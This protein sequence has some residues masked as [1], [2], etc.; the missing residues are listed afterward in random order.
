MTYYLIIY[1]VEYAFESYLHDFY[2]INY[3]NHLNCVIQNGKNYYSS[4][5]YLMYDSYSVGIDSHYNDLMLK[6][7]FEQVLFIIK[8]FIE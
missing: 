8:S 7:F 1:H 2:L 4:M 5:I 6:I 3:L